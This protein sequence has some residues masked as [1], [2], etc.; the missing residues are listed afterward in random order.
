MQT[1]INQSIHQEGG[2]GRIVTLTLL[3]ARAILV[4]QA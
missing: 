2:K 3:K 4:P 1:K